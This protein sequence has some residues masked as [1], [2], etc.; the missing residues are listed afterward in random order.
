[1]Q[2]FDQAILPVDPMASNLPEIVSPKLGHYCRGWM[3]FS[4]GGEWMEFEEEGA[5][6]EGGL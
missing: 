1:M 3:V 4:E 6:E 5:E 2:P